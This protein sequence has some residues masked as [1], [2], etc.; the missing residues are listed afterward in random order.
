[1]AV[2]KNLLIADIGGTNTRLR[3]TDIDGNTLYESVQDGIAS[4]TDSTSPLPTLEKQLAKLP[5]QNSIGAISINLGGR[6]TKQVS[7]CFRKFFPDVPLKI[8]RESE[9]TAAYALGEEYGAPIVL[10]AGTGAIAVGKSENGFVITGGW[11]ANIGD[12]GSGYDI[13]LQAIRMSLRSLDNTEALSPLTKYLC[14]CEEPLCATADPTLYRDKR[15]Q[16][17]EHLYPF[18]RQSIASLTK[19]VADFAEKG[20]ATALDIFK[21]AGEKLAEL[22][23]LTKKKLTGEIPAI[24]VTGGL[25]HSRKFWSPYFE[26]TIR[27]ILP[28]IKIHYIPDGLLK[29]TTNIAKDLYYKGGKK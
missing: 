24:V 11:G 14:C 19:I 12:D 4:T 7:L 2:I 6:N 18:D 25:I 20:D 26:S 21:Y 10:M 28:N 17:R 5:S 15:D 16:A 13:G 29:G 22:I 9:G 23:L 27:S 1:M 8:F 3:I